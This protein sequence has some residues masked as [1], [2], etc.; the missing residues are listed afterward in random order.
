MTPAERQ[1]WDAEEA[2]CEAELEGIGYAGDA[3][4]VKRRLRRIR[5]MAEQGHGPLATMQRFHRW[6]DRRQGVKR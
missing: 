1:A 6:C 2:R 5:E 4:T 3:K